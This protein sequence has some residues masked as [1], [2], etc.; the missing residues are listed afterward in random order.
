MNRSDAV[1]LGPVKK[2]TV[3]AKRSD[4]MNCFHAATG[5]IQW[6]QKTLAQLAV[7]LAR[8]SP[9]AR[10]SIIENLKLAATEML[11]SAK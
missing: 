7:M 1:Q 10:E 11:E 9:Q 8:C 3:L 5:F 6:H 4:P 2:L